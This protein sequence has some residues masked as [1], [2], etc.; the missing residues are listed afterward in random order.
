[1]KMKICSVGDHHHAASFATC[2]RAVL[3]VALFR[4]LEQLEGEL[5]SLELRLPPADF[6]WFV[7]AAEH[8]LARRQGV[9]Y[10]AS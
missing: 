9:S 5:Q 1:M 7:L 8:L 4:R 3:R 2:E 10:H 6:A